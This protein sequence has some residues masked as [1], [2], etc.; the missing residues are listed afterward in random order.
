[1]RHPPLSDLRRLHLP[2][3]R[4]AP[5]DHP[6]H[7]QV[8]DSRASAIFV[9]TASSLIVSGA[10]VSALAAAGIAAAVAAVLRLPFTA[11]LL[12]LLLCAA[13]GLAVTTPAI[14]GAVVGVLFR[15][16]ADARLHREPP[17]ELADES[18]QVAAS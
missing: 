16:V 17:E 3:R 5:P 10:N 6:R 9:A 14:I 18:P 8:F 2:L 11:V 7:G 4:D 15:V 1:M 13:A 12:A